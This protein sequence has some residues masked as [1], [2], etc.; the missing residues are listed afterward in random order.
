MGK[1]VIAASLLSALVLSPAFATEQMAEPEIVDAAT[2]KPKTEHDNTP[3][4]FNMEQNGK[5]MSA[6][7]FD[8]WMKARG[9]RVATGKPA[10]EAAS[11]PAAD[12]DLADK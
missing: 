1:I 11:A 4:R 2:Y 5:R 8:A 3:Y 10:V 12:T 6:D 9:V 7:E